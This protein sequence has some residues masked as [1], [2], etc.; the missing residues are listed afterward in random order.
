MAITDELREWKGN[1]IADLRPEMVLTLRGQLNGIADRI[2]E[3][4]EDA[5]TRLYRDMAD[6][7]YVTL[8]E[9]KQLCKKAFD[10]GADYG[11]TCMQFNCN[12]L[13]YDWEHWLKKNESLF[14][15]KQT[16]EDVL[17]EFADRVCNSGHQWGLDALDIVTEY[18]A[19]LRL[20]EE[21]DE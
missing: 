20:A 12:A 6:A 11:S 3:E 4:H 1:I 8:E 7:D 13:A 18:A 17:L 5:L 21:T 15:P 2:D 9:A 10:A 19:K 16:V 14:K